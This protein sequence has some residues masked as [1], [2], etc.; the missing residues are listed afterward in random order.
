MLV[1]HF[2][3][4]EGHH[5]DLNIMIDLMLIHI[6]I[7]IV[8]NVVKLTI[9]ENKSPYATHCISI[10]QSVM[11]VYYTL[12]Y[13]FRLGLA[14][15]F[16]ALHAAF[17]S[18]STCFKCIHPCNHLSLATSLPPGVAVV[19]VRH[20]HDHLLHRLRNLRRHLWL[21]HRN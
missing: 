21:P 20:R 18:D 12:Q 11:S 19:L 1:V 3:R 16:W 6:V 4:E 9:S 10:T 14:L 5:C 15:Y 13:P 2:V 7:M 17:F 8:L